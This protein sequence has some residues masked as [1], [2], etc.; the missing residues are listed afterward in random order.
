MKHNFSLKNRN[1]EQPIVGQ[2]RDEQKVDSYCTAA[3]YSKTQA[4]SDQGE[5]NVLQISH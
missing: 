3:V 4:P 1:K 5:E 2:A